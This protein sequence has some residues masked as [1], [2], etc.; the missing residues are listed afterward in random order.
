MDR[1]QEN[2]LRQFYNHHSLMIAL[3]LVI[4][5]VIVTGNLRSNGYNE[6]WI[7]TLWLFTVT[8][9]LLILNRLLHLSDDLG[10]EKFTMNRKSLYL[11]GL[12]VIPSVN[13]IAGLHFTKPVSALVFSS[14]SMILVGFIEE[15]IMRGYLFLALRKDSLVQAIV[16]SSVAFGV[17]HIAN[18]FTGQEPLETVLQIVYAF[19]VGLVFALVLVR[20]GNLWPCIITHSLVDFLSVYSGELS[21]QMYILVTMLLI[22]YCLVYSWYLLKKKPPLELSRRQKI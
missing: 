20:T 9:F 18:L 12:L 13:L 5:Y 1:N 15:V 7:M 8:I 16:I 2:G 10:L 21:N 14:I 19:G 22:I 3:V 6:S 11:L 17:G 4:A